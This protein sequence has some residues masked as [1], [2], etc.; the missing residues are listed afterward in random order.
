MSTI[1]RPK[2]LMESSRMHYEFCGE[3]GIKRIYQKRDGNTEET[4][5]IPSDI[6]II[7]VPAS[8]PAERDAFVNKVFGGGVSQQVGNMLELPFMFSKAVLKEIVNV[9]PNLVG[10]ISTSILK[11]A[12]LGAVD[13]DTPTIKLT[14]TEEDTTKLIKVLND[15]MGAKVYLTIGAREHT[16]G[17]AFY[18]LNA[19]GIN[20]NSLKDANETKEATNPTQD[21]QGDRMFKTTLFDSLNKG[22]EPAMFSGNTIDFHY[23]FAE[24][25][26]RLTEPLFFYHTFEAEETYIEKEITIKERGDTAEIDGI[27]VATAGRLQI[28]SIFGISSINSGHSGIMNKTEKRDY[29]KELCESDLTA[30][31]TNPS[32]YNRG[33]TW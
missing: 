28:C 31:S 2:K 10:K 25:F 19:S 17:N 23:S 30:L 32:S 33:D 5:S 18:R 15:I 24:F 16:D 14:N 26:C 8:T 4:L 12:T 29:F 3:L 22:I 7:Q 6:K 13:V 11:I 9:I 27:D 21:Q 1:I 20:V